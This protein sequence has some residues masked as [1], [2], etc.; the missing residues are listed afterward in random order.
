MAGVPKINEFYQCDLVTHVMKMM[1]LRSVWEELA[2]I[3]RHWKVVNWC[4]YNKNLA[5]NTYKWIL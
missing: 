3:I 1:Y 5:S 4:V 2:E